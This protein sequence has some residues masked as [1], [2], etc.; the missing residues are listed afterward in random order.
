MSQVGCPRDCY[1]TCVLA[2]DST[3]RNVDGFLTSG[4]TCARAAADL[5][6]VSSKNRIR[7]PVIAADK[8]LGLYRR[9]TLDKAID[10]LVSRVREI[11]DK[12]GADKILVVDYAGNRGVFT[13]L[14]PLRF[15][16]LLGATFTDYNI[17]DYSGS[18]GIG[19]HYG[20]DYGALPE[21]IY[22]ARLIVYWG[23]NAAVSNLH[24]FKMALEAKRIRGTMI[25]TIDVRITETMKSSDIRILIRPGSDGVLALGLA[26]Y[27]IQNELYD[28]RFVE[29]YT[30]GFDQFRE[31][32]KKYDLDYVSRYTGLPRRL[33]EEF[34]YTYARNKPS[35]IFVGYGLQRRYGGGEAVR[36]ISLLPALVGVHR[37]FFY[38][39]TSGLLLPFN[40]LTP[41]PAR[42][43]PQSM[44]AEYLEKGDFKLVFIFL[45]NPA[46]TYPEA[47]RIKNNLLRDDLFVVVHETHWSDTARLAD[48]VIPAP[49]YLEKEDLVYSYWHNYLIYNKPLLP[50]PPESIS[51]LD[52]ARR[53]ADS[54]GI[55][56][57]YLEDPW[58]KLS[59]DTNGLVERAR[60]VRIVEIPYRRLDEYQTPSG[61]IEF[62]SQRAL[63]QGYRPF[64][65]PVAPRVPEGYFVL[66]SGSHPLY[67]HSQFED[68]YG[69]I[70]SVAFIS[71]QD[72]E[73]YGLGNNDLVEIFNE[74]GSVIM[75]A[76]ITNQIPQGIIFVYR[77]AW[78]LDNS[79]INKLVDP[80]RDSLGG[81]VYNS[82]LVQI[83]KQ[84]ARP[85]AYRKR[86]P[87][88]FNSLS[89]F[90]L[91]S[92]GSSNN[93][94]VN[95]SS[96]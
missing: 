70:P 89:S 53:L 1:D 61:K 35:L 67:T 48:L 92:C 7:Y 33:I 83:R 37:G 66:V 43:I 50:R 24:G 55:N 41:S 19:L 28:K 63:M 47:E 51:E 87:K 42:T 62:Y 93:R 71:V 10:V 52:L 78:T 54:L 4:S 74:K 81:A 23:V 25:A 84:P 8:E 13:R 79:R 94:S 31:Y 57:D 88:S 91:N 80:G 26:N 65:E 21:S 90:S 29:E 60:Q 46:A 45:T 49:T 27:I 72:A 30:Y 73:Q 76:R 12:Y 82:T 36:A 56:D 6:R 64:P 77:S 59:E 15:W 20:L 11:V 69:R 34:A 75:R 5:K 17:C 95:D 14:L 86:F 85:E 2:L 38:S 32:V 96:R 39:N 58:G 40:R 22:K 9:I 3:L 44:L 18:I 16:R 68:V